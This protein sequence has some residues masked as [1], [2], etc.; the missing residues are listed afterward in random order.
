MG[1]FFDR[2]RLSK[3]RP[4][5]GE[6]HSWRVCGMGSV[7]FVFG[8]T[9][10]GKSAFAL[11]QASAMQGKKI[12]VATA[13]ALDQEMEERIAR[14]RHERGSNWETLEE[15]LHLGRA[16][17]GLAQTHDV[18]IIDCLTLWLSN[19][20]GA[21]LSVEETQEDFVESLRTLTGSTRIFVVSNEVGMGIVPENEMARQFRDM[22][23]R[24]N[25]RVAGVADECFLVAA[26]IPLK[27]K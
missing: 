19:I 6:L 20:L 2:E 17:R 5:G 23:G 10:S 21:G 15:P 7:V 18:A 14:H 27:I 3:P 13:Q 24:L 4:V 12:Y 26:G 9:R 8:G 11:T 16:V 25:Q 22:A 1:I